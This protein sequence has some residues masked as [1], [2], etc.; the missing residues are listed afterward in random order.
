MRGN[1]SC[2]L[3]LDNTPVALR[4][5]LGEEGDQLWSVFQVVAPYFLMAMAGTY[6]G[7]ATAALREAV[8]HLGA[9]Q[10]RH[11]GASLAEVGVL[12]HRTGVLWAMV[13]R[14]RRFVYHAATQ[15]DA[16]AED[17][18]P[19]ILSSKA[20]VADRAVTMANESLTMLGGIGYPTRRSRG[21]C[22][23]SSG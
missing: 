1:S 19:F 20:E 9:R 12:Q 6:L 13:E 17:A 14:T 16:G 3:D 8:N 5:L 23:R 7:I 11:S 2:A 22:R 10:H 18:L 4:D 21:C 15:G